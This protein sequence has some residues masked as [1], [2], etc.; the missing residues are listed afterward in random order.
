MLIRKEIRNPKSEVRTRLAAIALAVLA[1]L[2]APGCRR[3]I[4]S[5]ASDSDAN[6]YL[7]RSCKA[8]L[9]TDRSVF[10]GP[11]CPK[12]QQD[13]LVEAVGYVCEKDNH[14]T[15]TGRGADRGSSVCEQCGAPVSAMRLPR[16][17]DLKAWG[18]TKAS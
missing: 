8:K 1:A 15:I 14:L 18:A 6:G 2:V 13:D 4:A 12:C 10:I 3:D 11:K 16:E 17:K 9:F 7:C 5:E